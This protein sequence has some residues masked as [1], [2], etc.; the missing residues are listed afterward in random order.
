MTKYSAIV[1]FSILTTKPLSPLKQPEE[2]PLT[3]CKNILI[4]P[5]G[6]PA[7]R[8]EANLKKLHAHI[9][10]KYKTKNIFD[11]RTKAWRY[12][13]AHDSEA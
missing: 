5:R 3:Y 7:P 1:T 10:R 9:R 13:K 2:P 4:M 12:L 8:T 11:R 6:Y